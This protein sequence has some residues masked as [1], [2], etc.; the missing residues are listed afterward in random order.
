MGNQWTQL[1]ESVQRQQAGDPGVLGVV[2][3]LRRSAPPADQIRIDRNHH[4]PGVDQPIHQQPVPS[5]D[6]HPY[7]GRIA[8]QRGD[9]IHQRVDRSWIVAHPHHLDDPLT[10]AAQSDQ[11]KL[12]GPINSHPQ[13]YRLLS[14]FTD[15][16]GAAPC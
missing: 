15:T 16:G 2:F 12:L 13:H 1:S 14:T 3:L 11:M 7:L 6:H 5:L 9:L 10:G 4:E 8:L